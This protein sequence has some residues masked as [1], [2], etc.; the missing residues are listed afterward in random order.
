M[1]R[2]KGEKNCQLGSLEKNF[3]STWNKWIPS[4]YDNHA[5]YGMF[6]TDC[7]SEI[8]KKLRWL[9]AGEKYLLEYLNGPQNNCYRDF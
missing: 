9:S 2:K 3:V 8:C 4:I 6:M 5:D 7:H 1:L